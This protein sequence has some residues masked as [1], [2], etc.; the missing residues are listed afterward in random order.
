MDHL[1]VIKEFEI[2]K[3]I[4]DNPSLKNSIRLLCVFG[5]KGSEVIFATKEDKVYGF[6]NNRYG[7]LGV[8]VNG[9]VSDPM[10]NHT[11][12]GKRLT[13]LS[14]GYS[15]CMAL[16]R[17]GQVFGWGEN[18]YGQLGCG[19]TL[20]SNT[21]KLIHGLSDKK[22]R[23]ISCGNSHT[24]VLTREGRVYGF[25]RNGLGQLGDNSLVDRSTPVAIHLPQELTFVSVCCGKNHSLA[26]T[27]TG[28]VYMWGYSG[29][30]QLGRPMDVNI[31]GS[32]K[33]FVNKPEQLISL[34]DVMITKAQC[35]PNNTLLLSS[36]GHIYSFG[37]SMCGQVGNGSRNPQ[38][39]PVRIGGDVQFKDII[40]EYTFGIGI[41]I[42]IDNEYY[43]WGYQSSQNCVRISDDMTDE[44]LI[45]LIEFSKHLSKAFNYQS[46]YDLVFR[47]TDKSIYCHKFILKIRN[48]EFYEKCM[49]Q[50]MK[51]V[52]TYHQS[53]HEIYI[54]RYSYE[55]FYAFIGFLYGINPE[56]NVNNRS[57]VS[58]LAT[59]YD[60]P[61]LQEMCG[62]GL[63]EE[64]VIE[65][66]N[67]C[68]LYEKAVNEGLD[69]L[70]KSC[71]EFAKKH[72]QDICK[73]DSFDAMSEQMSKR[74]MRSLFTANDL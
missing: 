28:R 67:V 45:P 32:V 43:L 4:M 40:T 17:E 3:P 31:S 74:L 18:T 13:D 42:S 21:P 11:L 41:A 44:D 72:F 2:L 27:D 59:I 62:Q 55:S 12:T 60:E 57:D 6:G 16:T 19:S 8:G 5:I 54:K 25:G 37:A 34:N 14:Y 23:D 51:N 20:D 36:E 47:F 64:V 53:S 70:E 7:L 15:F 24:L 1:T 73:S 30:G 35:G 66:S 49:D 56:I 22:V 61:I 69:D 50:L 58:K 48:K 33:P 39:T 9:K 38:R 63:S 10:V 71:V 46:D 26:L 29:F 65:L 68:N 52:D